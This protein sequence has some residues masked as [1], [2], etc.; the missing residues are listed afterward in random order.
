[1]LFIILDKFDLHK[2]NVEMIN[3]N[4]IIVILVIKKLQAINDK[5]TTKLKIEKL[6]NQIDK[7]GGARTTDNRTRS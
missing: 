5:L 4:S 7:S 6:A 3:M 2:Q 1:M